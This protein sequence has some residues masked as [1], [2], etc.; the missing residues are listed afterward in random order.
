MGE[1]T[2]KFKIGLPEYALL[3]LIA[4][5][6]YGIQK[7]MEAWRF[8]KKFP[9]AHRER[10]YDF[11]GLSLVAYVDGPAVATQSVNWSILITLAGI[12]GTTW[13]IFRAVRSCCGK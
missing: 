4:A 12:P 9:E 1:T 6:L 2:K 3:L 10:F 13:L 11:I 5:V 8:L 7:L